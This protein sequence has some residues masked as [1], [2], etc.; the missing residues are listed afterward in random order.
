MKC[1]AISALFI[2]L[3]CCISSCT[4][5]KVTSIPKRFYFAKTDTIVAG[6]F[7]SI[8]RFQPVAEQ[9]LF[10]GFQHCDAH[11]LSLQD[12]ERF[13]QT[14]K[15]LPDYSLRN[16]HLDLAQKSGLKGVFVT[17]SIMDYND[18]ASGIVS[19]PKDINK[20]FPGA[21]YPPNPY[22]TFLF[23]VVDISTGRVL[24]A[25]KVKNTKSTVGFA[26]SGY[27]QVGLNTGY[28]I[29]FPE[30]RFKKSLDKFLKRCHCK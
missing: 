5:T 28:T 27:D 19:N 8:T 9:I 7:S 29:A 30:T 14:K 2:Q 10:K 3:T 23:Q 25:T 1:W 4:L 12:L 21:Y 17:A 15:V 6:T 26:T 13:A 24:L 22:I 11:I 20:P 16:P 18:E